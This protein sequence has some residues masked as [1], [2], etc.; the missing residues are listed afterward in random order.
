KKPVIK[1]SISWEQRK[2]VLVQ[3]LL[4][5][6]PDNKSTI[7]KPSRS[8]STQRQ[9]NDIHVFVDNSNISIGFIDHIKASRGLKTV[10]ISRP[11]LSFRALSLILERGRPAVRRVLVGSA[12]FTREMIEA[13]E[14]GYETS[15]LER[16]EKDRPDNGQ[17]SASSGSDTAANKIRRRKVEQ[18]VDEILHMKICESLLDHNP[19]TVVLAS[20]DGNI[21]EYSP[22]FFKAIERCLDRNWR[23]EVVAFKNSLNS[24]YR[25]KEFRKKWKGKFRV[26]L[27]DDFAEDMLS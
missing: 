26:I 22:G 27:L 20:G 1:S 19:S 13:K 17:R 10:N 24:V 2:S 4:N 15:V 23:V 9:S 6:F 5:Q 21:A 14:I 7:L 12:P 25:N 16:V 11:V 8:D 3:K 18:G